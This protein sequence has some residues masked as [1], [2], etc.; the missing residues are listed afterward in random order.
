MYSC[1][2]IL[3]NEII[4]Y[5][6]LDRKNNFKLASSPDEVKVDNSPEEK[7]ALCDN[8]EGEIENQVDI[9]YCKALSNTY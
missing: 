2:V 5:N 6:L 9:E 8:S 4:N 3:R 1:I 7:E